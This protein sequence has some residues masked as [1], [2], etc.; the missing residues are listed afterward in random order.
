MNANEKS[1]EKGENKWPLINA[2]FFFI[3][4]SLL[5]LFLRLTIGMDSKNFIALS[6]QIT[7][8]LALIINLIFLF[9]SCFCLLDIKKF[10]SKF[11]TT[12]VVLPTSVSPPQLQ[13]GQSQLQKQDATKGITATETAEM[14]AQ[15]KISYLNEIKENISNIYLPL[16]SKDDNY[17]INDIKGAIET[18]INEIENIKTQD[19][20]QNDSKK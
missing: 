12:E 14:E 11:K 17:T 6:L 15:L 3:L 19:T 9:I 2:I 20:V 16:S 5:G 10:K 7:I 8:G 13:D 18:Y 4:T 1:N